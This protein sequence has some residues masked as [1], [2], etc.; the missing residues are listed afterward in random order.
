MGIYLGV[1]AGGSKTHALLVDAE[2]N[3]LGTGLSGNGNHQIDRNGAARNVRSACEAALASAGLRHEDVNFAYFGLAGA[4]R[5]PDYVIL[6]PMIAELGFARH[7]FVCDTMIGMRA[8]TDRPYGG[9]IISGTGFNSAA[10]N[11]YGDELQYGGYGHLFGDGFGAGS[12]LAVLAFRS[13]IREWDGRGEATGLTPLILKEMNYGNVEDM[14]TDVLDNGVS[15]PRDLV[16]C[17]FEAAA[18]GDAVAQRIL[19]EEGTELGN[20]VN[21]LIRRLNMTDDEFDVV[22][23]GSVLMRGKGSYLHDAVS[24]EVSR[25]AP[26]ARC[27]RLQSDPVVGAVLSAMDEEGVIISPELD[28]R[29]KSFTFP[30]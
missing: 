3:V 30:G 27:V 9:V 10:R 2:G 4:D 29:L 1:D 17:L 7:A 11:R 15:V 13:V 18:E 6:R 24:R 5:E 25:V 21:A 12:S 23:I 26:K 19:E 8:G 20:A 14:Y 28:A 22:L 16:K